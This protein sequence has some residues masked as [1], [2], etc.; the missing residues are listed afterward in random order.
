[1]S[2]VMLSLLLATVPITGPPEVVQDS[3]RI[4][5]VSFDSHGSTIV[6]RFF[7]AG[8]PGARPTLLLLPG[9]PGNPDDVLGLGGRLSKRGVNVL[10]VLPRGMHGSQGTAT[11][12]N[13]LEDIAVALGWLRSDSVAARFAVDRGTLAIGGYSWGGGVA[14][15]YAARDSTVRHVVSIAGT[16]HGEF[17]RMMQ[18]DPVMDAQ[19]R[20]SL[21]GSVAPA[22]PNRGDVDAILRELAEGQA[23][24]GLREN[25]G[26]LADR[27]ILLL[28]GWKDR[29]ITV[30]HL[31]LPLY[32]ELEAEGAR[33]LTFLTYDDTHTFS[34]V[35]DRLAN[36]I[37]D[38]ISGPDSTPAAAVRLQG[39]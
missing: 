32:R 38:W 6:G 31:L 21:A 9:W 11:M 16:D 34:G 36:D 22:G 26:A 12:A 35:R 33:D 14:M 5:P 2:S 17:I 1:M 24:Y 19:V 29:Q 28:G 7:A 10:V 3:V 23:I 20:A 27:R 18:R 39:A 4:V 37:A 13:A 15:A 30:D 25:A 8:D